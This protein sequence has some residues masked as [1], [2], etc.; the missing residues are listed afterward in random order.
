[1]KKRALALLAAS[2]AI[3]ACNSAPEPAGIEITA[4]WSR[5]TPPG[6]TTGAGYF[7]VKNHGPREDRLIRV[8]SPIAAAVELHESSVDAN[9]MAQM[10]P[11]ESVP[12]PPG[13][14]VRF[15]PEGK[16]LMLVDLRQPLTANERVP[17]TLRFERAPAQTIELAVQ[18]LG[19][20]GP[21]A[22]EH[23]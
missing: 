2:L 19:G 8:E 9:G 4:A 20:D 16:H 6:A 17:I 13:G 7:T 11:L 15:E 12:L 18:P 23:H 5:A 22:H 3:V 10:R 21:G 1:M 14:E